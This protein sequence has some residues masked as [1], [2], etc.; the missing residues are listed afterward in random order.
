M[1]FYYNVPLLCY[2]DLL[3]TLLYLNYY[4]QLTFILIGHHYHRHLVI[5]DITCEI[6]DRN[7]VHVL[8]NLQPQ[9]QDSYYCHVYMKQ[10]GETFYHQEAGYN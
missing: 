9:K 7:K 2:Y 4:I 3:L 10:K 6:K 8:Y 5:Q 1:C